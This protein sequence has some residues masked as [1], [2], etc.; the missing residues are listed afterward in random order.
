MDYGQDRW[1]CKTCGRRNP[2]GVASDESGNCE[3]CTDAASLKRTGI[4]DDPAMREEPSVF[5]LGPGGEEFLRR[6]VV[7][8]LRKKYARARE[9]V[10]S[11]QPDLQ[12]HA[13]LDWVLGT[14][15]NPGRDDARFD[16]GVC[17][18]VVLWLEDFLLE[19]DGPVLAPRAEK[20]VGSLT[21]AG[22]S[23]LVAA[24]ALRSAT[25]DFAD[26]FL[27]IAAQPVRL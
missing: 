26:A 5:P 8:L 16:L 3:R 25:R 19:L 12:P 10:G 7:D 4:A 9:L 18:L 14:R 13:H 15:R 23:R 21:P 22:D 17:Q 27:G 2:I 24:R 1:N 11:G 6:K 20:S